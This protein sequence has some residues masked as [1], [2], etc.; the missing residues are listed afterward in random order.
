M[1]G[2]FFRY[3]LRTIAIAGFGFAGLGVIGAASAEGGEGASVLPPEI[4]AGKASAAADPGETA[5]I[6]TK[7]VT[8]AVSTFSTTSRVADAVRASAFRPL[9]VR[10]ALEHNLPVE[11]ADAVVRIESRYNAAARNGPNL[12]LTQVNFRTAQSLGYTGDASGLFN[13]ETNLRYGLKYLAQAYKLAG[14]DLCGA[15]LRYQG[16]HRART[17]TD[18]SRAYCAKV[19]T[20]IAK[21]E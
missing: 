4:V 21:A 3:P 14:G 13:A 8:G 19:K 18:A 10:Y 5:S 16:G 17:M 7:P 2:M 15:I 12:G 11:L 20:I 6:P 9:I 1:S